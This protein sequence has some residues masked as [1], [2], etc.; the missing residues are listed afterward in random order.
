MHMR[1]AIYPGTFDPITN[2]HLSL[3]LRGLRI[4]DRIVV[5]VA[6][7]TPKKALFSLSERL[8]IVRHSVQGLPN[9]KVISFS[10]LVVD[11]AVRQNASVILRGIRALADFEKEFQQALMN[12]RLNHAVETVFFMTDYQWLFTSSTIVKTAVQNGAS[13]CGLTSEYVQ[14]CIEKAYGMSPVPTVPPA[15]NEAGDLAGNDEWQD[16]APLAGTGQAARTAIYPGTF[17]PITK[18]HLSIIRRAFSLFDKV[19]VAV[20]ENPGKNPLYSLDERVEFVRK[21]VEKQAGRISVMPY[22]NLTVDAAR[23]VHASAII[24]GLRAVGDFEYEFQMALMN[25][26][27]N[28]SVETVFFMT[29][30]KWLYVS[31]SIVKAS[32]SHGASVEGLVPDDVQKSLSSLYKKGTI[33]EATPCLEAPAQGYLRQE[34]TKQGK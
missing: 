31:S 10:G 9:V 12:R 20:A 33:A 19:I 17:D 4:F 7:T 5:A 29:D 25:R 28:R 2:G 11:C 16:L 15:G 26:R 34:A 21:A 14:R 24:R 23:K 3:I 6:E 22:D 1:I 8:E 27:L 13:T 32:A 30:Y 18:G